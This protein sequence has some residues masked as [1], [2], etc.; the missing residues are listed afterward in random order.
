MIV[1]WPFKNFVP[2]PIG[3]SMQAHHFRR[4]E[5]ATPLTRARP[6]CR[7][8]GYRSSGSPSRLVDTWRRH[9]CRAGR[10]PVVS[11]RCVLGDPAPVLFHDVDLVVTLA[12]SGTRPPGPIDRRQERPSRRTAGH[13]QR[14]GVRVRSLH[15]HTW[16]PDTMASPWR[17]RDRGHD[18]RYLEHGGWHRTRRYASLPA[19]RTRG[20]AR[21]VRR[22]NDCGHNRRYRRG[23]LGRGDG[24]GKWMARAHP[25]HHCWWDRRLRC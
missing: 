17:R 5:P 1:N 11:R 4:R 6:S 24:K 8:V 14:R 18:V 20:R 2:Y 7:R 10:C 9:R 12:R 3:A 13:R 22:H 23:G 19:Q 25:R 15:V 16:R 21:H